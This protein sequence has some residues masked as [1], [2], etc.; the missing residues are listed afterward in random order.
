[1]TGTQEKLRALFLSALMVM[2]V[3]GAT[4]AF[5]G[6]AAA[7][8]GNLNAPNQ[9]EVGDDLTV[10]VDVAN[11]ETVTINN[12]VDGE[13]RESITVT[14]GGAADEDGAADGSIEVTLTAGKTYGAG[15]SEVFVEDSSGNVISDTYTTT[16]YLVE[17]TDNVTH[18]ETTEIS[19]E[20][21]EY[22]G[23]H[24]EQTMR[25]GLHYDE[26]LNDLA[27]GVVSDLVLADSDTGDGTFIVTR[28]FDEVDQNDYRNDYPS[29]VADGDEVGNSAKDEPG[30]VVYVQEDGNGQPADNNEVG[31][32]VIDTRLDFSADTDPA[33]PVYKDTTDVINGDIANANG[34][35]DTYQIQ[36]RD[37]TGATAKTTS[38]ASDGSFSFTAETDDAGTWT[39]G[40]SEGEFIQY[41]EVTVGPQ[42]ADLTFEADGANKANFQETYSITLQDSRDGYAL[43]TEQG[44]D[45]SADQGHVQGYVNVSGPFEQGSVTGADVLSTTDLDAGDNVVDYVEVATDDNG[46]ASFSAIPTDNADVTATLQLET[47]GEFVD[48]LEEDHDA[49]YSP[50][51][52][53]YTATETVPL[54]AA[55]PV[56]IVDDDVEDP[57][58]AYNATD[59]T[60]SPGTWQSIYQDAGPE[61]IEVLPLTDATGNRITNNI[62]LGY[63]V[64]Y[65]LEGMTAYRVSFELRDQQN[66]VI[67]PGTATGDFERMHITGAGI[68]AVVTENGTNALTVASGENVLDVD[69]SGSTYQLL[70]RPTEVES[71]NPMINHTIDVA[72]ESNVT[73]S[74]DANG[75]NIAEFQ[76]DGST[77]DVVQPNTV[78]DVTSVVEDATQGDAPINNGRVRM[79][80][81]GTEL[82]NFDARTANTNN[83]EYSFEDVDV[84]PRGYDNDGDGIGEEIS[85]LD[86]TAYQYADADDDQALVQREVNKAAVEQLD[87]AL[88]DTLQVEYDA[89]NTSKYSGVSDGNFTLTRGVEYDQIAFTLTEADGTPVDLTEGQGGINVNLN[90]IAYDATGN[91]PMLVTLQTPNGPA[92]VRFDTT[93]SDPA[94][95]YYVIEDI[96]EVGNVDSQTAGFADESFVFGSPS[97]DAGALAYTLDIETPDRSQATASDTGT[98][99][100]ADATLDTEVAGVAGDAVPNSV[101]DA[102]G[103]GNDDVIDELAHDQTDWAHFNTNTSAIE[104]ATANVDRVYRINATA[105]DALGTP[106]NDS[107]FTH[108]QVNFEGSMDTS[109][110]DADFQMVANGTWVNPQT[111]NGITHGLGATANDVVDI[112]NENGAFQFDIEVDD[113]G[114]DGVYEPIFEI[115]AQADASNPTGT[116]GAPTGVSDATQSP[117]IQNPVVNVFGQNGGDLPVNEDSDNQILAND[118]PNQLR[119]E[120]FPADED[121][122]VLPDGLDFALQGTFAEDNVATSTQNIE[123]V[124]TSQLAT[125]GYEEGQIGFMQATPTGTGLN[126]A[127]LLFS[128]AQAQDTNGDPIQFDVLSSNRQIGLDITPTEPTPDQNITV[129]ATDQSTFEP[130]GQVS[131]TVESPTGDTITVLTDENGEAIVPSSFTDESG[132]YSISTRRAGYADASTSVTID[133]QEPASFE[134]TNLDAPANATAGE[135]IDVTATIENTGDI[136]DSQPV[137]YILGDEVINITESIELDGGESVQYTF[138][139]DTSGINA[140]EYTHGVYTDADEMTA[141]ITIEEAATEN[142][143][144]VGEDPATDTDGDGVLEDVNG[145]GE[146]TVTD[147]QAL[148]AN[149]NSDAVQN[150]PELF[151]FNGDGSFSVSDVQALFF[152]SL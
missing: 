40:T 149:R 72:G 107:D 127:N 63:D 104:T 17:V 32:D 122:F 71:A 39:V 33:E 143:I 76:V 52:P 148:F 116:N 79:S 115:E 123:N 21:F 6:T 16:D 84:G 1:M 103:D 128:N 111:G 49:A 87:I 141:S 106:L 129:T 152:Q 27:Q 3:F 147:V 102:A 46:E 28:T 81:N 100:T 11:G 95:G 145:D 73:Y 38:T 112:Q 131:V 62:R 66:N 8:A 132:S 150:N 108:I 137:M 68:D 61:A 35:L 22:P 138:E 78:V 92:E 18:G 9:T 45:N 30:Y 130:V 83:G 126:F 91:D 43:N 105:T 94:D 42:E 118:L 55:N 86:F 14:D 120:A 77:T 114:A 110:D 51:S 26:N 75:L 113:A 44:G 64:N 82:A 2:S 7:N 142:P 124:A 15:S 12:T 67:A 24:V 99:V 58:T 65:D 134:V 133:I 93:A 10:T 29:D 4:V 119:V 97:T 34:G 23:D 139:V 89:E 20:I 140:S 56:N 25:W 37:P 90:D 5:T 80:Q 70:V 96:E 98:F 54:G 144:V 53:D 59:V 48:G 50:T 19:G 109:N 151:D 101:D 88:D 41:K 31:W 13:E 125:E 36:F 117:S 60:A 85:T 74:V 146:F 136:T 135:T 69:Y 57:Q 121:G 47:G